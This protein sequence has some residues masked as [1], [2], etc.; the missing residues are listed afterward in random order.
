MQQPSNNDC[1]N[2]GGYI[3]AISSGYTTTSMRSKGHQLLKQASIV[4][5]PKLP[6]GLQIKSGGGV[7]RPTTTPW[8]AFLDPDETITP[9]RGIYLVYIFN[10][11]L[12]QVVLT[13]NQGITELG[14]AMSPTDA[15]EHLKRSAIDLRKRLGSAVDGLTAPLNFGRGY[16]QRGY[17]AANIAAV[18]YSLLELPGEED[19]ELDLQRMLRLYQEALWVR[20]STDP[21]PVNVQPESTPIRASADGLSLFRPNSRGQYMVAMREGMSLRDGSRHEAL[22]AQYAQCAEALGHQPRNIGVHP[23]DL[24]L[25]INGSEWLVEAKVVYR[26]NATQAVRAALSQLLEY[27]FVLYPFDRRPSLMALFSEPVGRL[28]VDLL[29]SH[30]IAVVW[31]GNYGWSGS[32]LAE[33]ANL[34]CQS[35]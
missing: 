19:L 33:S 1:M 17:A 34:F 9:Q 2:I 5:G 12:S 23:R 15:R 3:S 25:S 4:F 28:Y 35:E 6:G 32:I 22:I 31:K 7:G 10:P 20:G 24:T 11:E 30:D 18:T 21:R 14:T 13:L 29:E 8:I 26:G 16:R 27:A